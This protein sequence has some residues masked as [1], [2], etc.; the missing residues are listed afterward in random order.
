MDKFLNKYRIPSARLQNWDYGWN[1]SY[2]ITICTASRECFFGEIKNGEMHL[3][4]IGKI[5]EYE[6]LNTPE[7]RP[8]MNLILGPFMVMPNHFHAIIMIGENVYN[9]HG[10]ER[11][12]NPGNERKDA[13]HGVST[14]ITKTGDHTINPK[15]GFRPQRKNLASIIRG[16]KS[17]VTI[18]ARKIHTGFAWQSRYY[19]HIIRNEQSYQT[20]SDYIINNPAKW[21]DDNFFMK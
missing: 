10:N 11:N 15:N 9:I 18:N 12:N 1:A 5:V 17:A 21:N 19:D 6:W 16:F 13:M 20:I 8:D 2:F 7:I 3:S 14:F 4:E